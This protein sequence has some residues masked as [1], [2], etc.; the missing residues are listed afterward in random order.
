[1]YVC[2]SCSLPGETQPLLSTC[3]IENYYSIN[4]VLDQASEQQYKGMYH[5]VW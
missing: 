5:S 3:S 1:M 2:I 4:E